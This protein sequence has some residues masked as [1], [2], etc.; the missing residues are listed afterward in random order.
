[1]KVK[2]LPVGTPTVNGRIY[3]KEVLKA[4]LE[5]VDKDRMI[6]VFGQEIPSPNVDLHYAAACVSD[7]ELT[8]DSLYGNVEMLNTP[9]GLLAQELNEAYEC[10]PFG[11]GLLNENN[12]VSEYELRGF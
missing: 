12:E 9:S 6:A 1:M 3:P 11:V 10:R 5:K 7:L 8:E 2:L 4:A